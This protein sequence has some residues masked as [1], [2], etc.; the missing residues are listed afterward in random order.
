MLQVDQDGEPEHRDRVRAHLQGLHR[1][2]VHKLGRQRV[3]VSRVCVGAGVHPSHPGQPDGAGVLLTAC[4]I[5][6]W[7]WQSAARK[8]T[9]C[10]LVVTRAWTDL[11]V[12]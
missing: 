6:V 1:L 12:P 5:R 7:L 9:L 10:V 4:T 2:R 11:G 3:H 8:D